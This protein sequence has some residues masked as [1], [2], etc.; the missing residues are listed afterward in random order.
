VDKKELKAVIDKLNNHTITIAELEA[1]HLFLQ[2]HSDK[3]LFELYGSRPMQAQFHPAKE[4]GINRLLSDHRITKEKRKLTVGSYVPLV[5]RWSAVAAA[6]IGIFLFWEFSL[7][8]T[9]I[10]QDQTQQAVAQ[11][12]PGSNKAKILLEGG[13]ILDLATLK[14]DTT[15]KLKGYAIRKAK[16][17]SV[18]YLN[19]TGNQEIYHTIVTPIGGQY[20]LVLADG[21]KVL[22][23]ASSTLRYPINFTGPK[24]TVQLKGEAYFEVAKQK[25]ANTSVPFIVST[26]PQEIEVLGTEFNVNN[27]TSEISTTLIEGSVRLHF[28]DQAATK[29]LKPNQQSVYSTKS[30]RVDITNIDPFYAVAWKEGAFAFENTPISEVMEQIARW[31]NVSISF[32]EDMRD[33]SFSGRISKYSEFSKLL[34]TIELT[35]SVRFQIEG[36]RVLVMH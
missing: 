34:K 11:I 36:R 4:H 9:D 8:K 26:G 10:Q 6:F 1:L 16:D 19:E 31:Y 2:Q 15:I 7:S 18:S 12:V 33:V 24:R 21:T 29:L 3:E 23:N 32:K 20:G 14:N 13:K 25:I 17:G 28:K 5:A 22:M 30:K 27:H 35:G